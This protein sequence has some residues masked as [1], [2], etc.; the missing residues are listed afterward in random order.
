MNTIERLG[1]AADFE[2]PAGDARGCLEVWYSLVGPADGR[3]AFWHRASLLR[4]RGGG[5]EAR[6][7]AALTDREAPERS[8]LYTERRPL[9]ALQVERDPFCLSIGSLY[10]LRDDGVEGRLVTE[11]GLVQWSLN[12]PTD[13][14]RF[15]LLR[16]ELLTRLMVARGSTRHRSVNEA[17]IGRA[18]CRERV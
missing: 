12:Y 10:A 8:F 11:S 4:L 5:G 17:E 9:E 13:P 15:T 2:W 14:Q 6:V 1:N 16:S 7:W 3:F 18:S